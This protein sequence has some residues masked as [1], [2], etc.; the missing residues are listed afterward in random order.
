M[1]IC[2]IY[3]FFYLSALCLPFAGCGSDDNVDAP[4]TI[5]YS[6]NKQG[7]SQ[8]AVDISYDRIRE[9]GLNYMLLPVKATGK[10]SRETKV[11]LEVDTSLI[12][13]YNAAKGTNRASLPPGA[14]SVEKT[15]LNIASGNSVSADSMRI[16][17][18][19]SFI[20][21]H[22]TELVKATY[23]IPVK[24]SSVQTEDKTVRLSA[25]LNVFYVVVD[26][27]LTGFVA[28]ASEKPGTSIDRS[29]WAAESRH[30]APFG[31]AESS[32]DNDLSTSWGIMSGDASHGI[33]Y[34]LKK[35][36]KLKGFSLISSFMLYDSYNCVMAG[37]NV[38]ISVD[39]AN[40]T[41]LGSMAPVILDGKKVDAIYKF[42]QALEARY[43]RI[44]PDKFLSVYKFAS[45]A[46]IYFYE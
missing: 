26:F 29:G 25:N 2:K 31:S 15:S 35:T 45:I 3:I 34:D 33:Y 12:K 4:D 21:K 32:F 42:E 22:L 9:S 1:K 38:G 43:V 18:N 8:V 39:G 46:E 6:N 13:G 28:K 20:E 24:I 5:I 27:S 23:V 16:V 17:F 44:L 10:V 19:K 14:Y 36:H 30:L 7:D 40:W 41:Y 37:F 11:Y